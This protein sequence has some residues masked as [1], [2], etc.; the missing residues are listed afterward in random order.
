MTEQEFQA[1]NQILDSKID[2]LAQMLEH[3]MKEFSQIL[4]AANQLAKDIK[5]EKVFLEN[6]KNNPPSPAATPTEIISFESIQQK[7]P[8][9]LTEAE[10]KFVR[11]LLDDKIKSLAE[12]K[13]ISIRTNRAIQVD[14]E[15]IAEYEKQIEGLQKHAESG[16]LPAA[17]AERFIA[18]ARQRQEELQKRIDTQTPANQ[19]YA[20]MV[21]NL[22]ISI[23]EIKSIVNGYLDE[24]RT[25]RNPARPYVDA[26]QRIDK[27]NDGSHIDSSSTLQMLDKM[28]AKLEAKEIAAAAEKEKQEKEAENQT[29]ENEKNA[30]A[31][32]DKLKASI[33]KKTESN[34]NP[35]NNP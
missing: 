17:D 15:A 34:D 23:R 10:F 29:A 5:E 14:T 35:P 13:A 25:F 20:A 24:A 8:T 9:K 2:A 27:T 31:M 19:K 11:N 7:N 32:L 30:A 1:L 18:E 28:R 21:S 3:K 12:V 4:A 22:E 26:T 6:Y 16:Q 33:A